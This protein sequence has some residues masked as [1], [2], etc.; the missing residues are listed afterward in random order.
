[1]SGTPQIIRIVVAEDHGVV[2]A[3]L[4]ALLNGQADMRVIGEAAT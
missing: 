2:R 3:G 4:S 1:M